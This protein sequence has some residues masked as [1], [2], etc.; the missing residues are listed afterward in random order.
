MFKNYALEI[1]WG[2]IFTAVALLWMVFEKMMGW[3]DEKIELH[4]TYTNFFAI[5]AIAVFVLA[6]LEKRRQLGGVMTWKQGFVAGLIISI[7]VAILSPPA[8]WITH[9]VI[10]PDY[11]ENATRYA[12]ESGQA[13]QAQAASYF[14]LSSYMVQG[15]VGGLIIG[16]VTSAILALIL[17]KKKPAT[18]G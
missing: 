15:A 11:F 1:K 4:P 13:T 17:Q 12:V 3:H 18:A 10:T 6:L 5:A 2:F 8:Q 16:V 9:T 7:V 14:N